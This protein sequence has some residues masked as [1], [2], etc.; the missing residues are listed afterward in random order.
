MSG[1]PAFD[2][3]GSD[4][5]DAYLIGVENALIAAGA[6]RAERMQVLQDLET[7]IAEMVAMRPLPP[8]EEAVRAVLDTLE[9]PA[10][11]AAMYTNG[12]KKNESTAPASL[13]T[14]RTFRL[15]RPKW[16]NVA[17]VS[18]AILACG[19]LFAM[20]AAAANGPNDFWILL[21]LLNCFVGLVFTPIAL[22]N[23]YRQLRSDLTTPG[24]G[25]VLKSAIVYGT[26]APILFVLWAAVVTEGLVPILLGIVALF[27]VQYVLLRRL[28]NYLSDAL[29]TPPTAT[30]NSSNR[31]A[32]PSAQQATPMPAL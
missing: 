28:W 17:A 5:I 27:Y 32:P 16:P 30:T 8:T 29:P 3:V 10:H 26:I 2:N 21:A 11:F 22:W 14:Q 6:P 25:L 13:A 23:A 18:V 15:T 4:I 19:C 20:I 24:R 7:Q 12:G 1:A 31:N 9:P